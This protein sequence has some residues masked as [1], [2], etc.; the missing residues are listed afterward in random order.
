MLDKK[1]FIFDFDGIIANSNGIKLEILIK[2]FS[3]SFGFPASFILNLIE[4]YPGKNRSFYIDHLKH[5]KNKKINKKKL[6][7]SINTV[8]S[9]NL[10]NAPLNP[11]LKQMRVFN[12][13]IDWFIITSGN[14]IEVKN[15]LKKK[16]IFS[17]FKDIVGGDDN[18]Y[19][20]YLKLKIKHKLKN[21]N[22]VVVGDGVKDFELVTKTG[23]E[24]FLILQWSKE[25]DFLLSVDFPNIKVL[26][27]L[28]EFK[29][30][31]KKNYSR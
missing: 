30:I 24:G 18:K 17:Y 13:E 23:G 25:N 4:S 10:L 3:K 11:H 15:F 16:K 8:M 9:I 12:E 29:L 1:F 31:Y 27:T 21:K 20:S 5:I 22:I 19:I 7:S 28:K 6:L 26:K 2:F 14:T